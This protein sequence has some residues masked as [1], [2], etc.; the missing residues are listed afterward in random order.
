MR[1]LLPWNGIT[2]KTSEALIGCLLT[3][4]LIC[5]SAPCFSQASKSGISE[6]EIYVKLFE[7]LPPELKI[8]ADSVIASKIYYNATHRL[9]EIMGA[10]ERFNKHLKLI[11]KEILK[12]N[13]P[14]ELRFLPIAMSGMRIRFYDNCNRGGMWGLPAATAVAGGLHI[15]AHWDERFDPSMSTQVALEHIENLHK[16]YNNWWHAIIAYSNGESGLRNAFIRTGNINAGVTEL[17]HHGNLPAKE[18]ITELLSAVF[19]YKH[20]ETTGLLADINPQT[21][22]D[23][24]TEKIIIS[25]AI[26]IPHLLEICNISQE[27]FRMLNPVYISNTL[28]PH[29]SIPVYISA[30]AHPLFINMEDSLYLWFHTPFNSI[31]EMRESR[32]NKIN[33]T[34]QHK[35]EYIVYVVKSGDILGSIARGHGVSVKDIKEWNKLKGD[36]IYPGQKL[37]ILKNSK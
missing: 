37:R 19:I 36:T 9:A 2:I 23:V 10:S 3:I 12:R 30:K 32:Q 21:T 13:I 33:A 28:I 14:E 31:A 29:P 5:L 15:N 11:D 34:S 17:Y 27:S 35:Q 18:V 24:D 20:M 6:K 22:Q 7:L 8:E 26:K 4:C 16:K 25:S 1:I